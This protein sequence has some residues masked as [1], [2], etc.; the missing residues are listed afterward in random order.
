MEEIEWN[1]YRF[2]IE[3]D[4]SEITIWIIDPSMNHSQP[5]F[6]YKLKNLN[7][8]ESFIEGDYYQDGM[9]KETLVKVDEKK[10]YAA[11]I[12][13]FLLNNLERLPEIINIYS[14]PLFSKSSNVYM[15]PPTINFWCIQMNKKPDIPVFYIGEL[16]RFKL[17]LRNV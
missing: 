5:V 4:R 15:T 8:I 10:S 3:R 6:D 7:G 16:K 11:L 14:S 13:N 1:N 2:Q 17:Q 12:H 9:N